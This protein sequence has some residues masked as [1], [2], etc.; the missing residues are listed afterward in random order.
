MLVTVVFSHDR[1]G[2]DRAEQFLPLVTLFK[3]NTDGLV[4]EGRTFAEV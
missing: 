1:F 4:A 3:S 2:R